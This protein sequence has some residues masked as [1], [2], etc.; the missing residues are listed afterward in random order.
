MFRRI[1]NKKCPRRQSKGQTKSLTDSKN[2]NNFC[3]MQ[4]AVQKADLMPSFDNPMFN[5][6]DN[7]KIEYMIKSLCESATSELPFDTW[8]EVMKAVILQFKYISN[9]RFPNETYKLSTV[10]VLDMLQKDL[11]TGRFSPRLL[12]QPH[13]GNPPANIAM[14]DDNMNRIA[15]GIYVGK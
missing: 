3:E 1:R 4:T 6:I 7:P 5:L 8:D 15:G 13:Y 10:E 2:N 9:N 12:E 11:L 14:T